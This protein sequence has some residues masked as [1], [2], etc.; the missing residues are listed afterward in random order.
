MGKH[1][2]DGRTM[3]SGAGQKKQE[4]SLSASLLRNEQQSVMTFLLSCDDD[5]SSPSM[6]WSRLRSLGSLPG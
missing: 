6:R 4:A 1:G 2:H 3:A 5:G